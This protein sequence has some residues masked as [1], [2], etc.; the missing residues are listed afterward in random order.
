MGCNLADL[1]VSLKKNG[2]TL[3]C[4]HKYQDIVRVSLSELPP[5]PTS[6]GAYEVC[7]CLIVVGTVTERCDFSL[8]GRTLTNSH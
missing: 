8:F 1:G 3:K 5:R 4:T 7:A 6:K 2:L